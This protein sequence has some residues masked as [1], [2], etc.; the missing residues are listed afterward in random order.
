MGESIGSSSKITKTSAS[1]ASS[2]NP[3]TP[4]SYGFNS[5]SPMERPIGQKVAKRKGKENEIPTAKQDVR[6]KRTTT[7]E[8]L[9]QCKE[10]EIKIKKCTF[11]I[12]MLAY[13]SL[14]DSVDEYVRINESTSIECL[15]RF[16]QGVNVVF[17]A[18]YLR[19]PNN[20]DLEHLLQMGKSHGFP[21]MLGSIDCMH[22]EWKNYP[23]SWKRQYCRGDHGKPTIMLEAMASQDLW[24]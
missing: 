6:N 10:D 9:A 13:G 16:V 24:I 19:K 11:V 15:Q 12:R 8:R 14:A 7:M 18:E 20:T 5:S 4:S 2:E 23:V 21:S 1:G 3:D 17:G 22:W